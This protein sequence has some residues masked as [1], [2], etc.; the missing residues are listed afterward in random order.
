MKIDGNII[1]VML[2][3]CLFVSCDG[4]DDG[5]LMR[6]EFLKKTISPAIVGER[7]EF[8]YAMGSLDGPLGTATATAS[9]AGAAGTGF[10]EYSYYTTRTAISVNGVNYAAGNDV[11][12]K[13][14]SGTSTSGN[15]STAMMEKLVD[16]IYVHPYVPYGSNKVN[17]DAATIRYF[18]VV[19][20]EARGKEV[21]FTFTSES[22]TGHK[23]FCTTPAYKVSK[24]DM[25]RLIDMSNDGACYF[26]IA[27]MTAYTREE[28][29]SRNLSGNIDF[30]YIY[31]NGFNGFTYGHA[32]ISPGS[33]AE[34]FARDA[35]ASSWTKNSTKMEK[36]VDVRDAQL[37]G[38]IPN[39]YIDDID[40]ETL[41]I[42]HAL[43]FVLNFV[44]DEG[45][46]MKTADSKYLAYIYVNSINSNGSIRVSIKRYML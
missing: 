16:E 33:G 10:E 45:A 18:Y 15:V 44:N 27:D 17:L 9:V 7:L 1:Y 28:V 19:P 41:Q 5:G 14:V 37:K 3:L 20:E 46:F 2:S 4:D 26:S 25:K 22:S 24:M 32:F 13:T 21:S 42:D 38:N 31:Q 43:D 11:P 34:Y 30:V 40:F 29:E 23:A 8:A 36:R 35:V 39:V 12:L 6:N